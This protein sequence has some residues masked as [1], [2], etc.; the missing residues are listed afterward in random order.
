MQHG[1]IREVWHA[2][3]GLEHEKARKVCSVA[4]QNVKG[5]LKDEDK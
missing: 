5:T 1:E 4:V 2:R 3:N